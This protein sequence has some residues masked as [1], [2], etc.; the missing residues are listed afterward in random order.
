MTEAAK[1]QEGVTVSAT[2]AKLLWFID[3]SSACGARI[4]PP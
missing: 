4:H 2:S 3:R 1:L